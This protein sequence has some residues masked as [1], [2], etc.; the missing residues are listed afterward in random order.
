MNPCQPV[1]SRACPERSRMGR[2]DPWLIKHRF[3]RLQKW[4]PAS[5]EPGDCGRSFC[6]CLYRTKIRTKTPK[7]VNISLCSLRLK[8]NPRNP[9]NPRLNIIEFSESSVPGVYPEFIPES[10]SPDSQQGN[11]SSLDFLS[12][13]SKNS[14]DSC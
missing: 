5:T 8:Q 2:M 12:G 10:C 1:L 3:R 6:R 13:V 7:P 11:V 14:F 9:C 4:G